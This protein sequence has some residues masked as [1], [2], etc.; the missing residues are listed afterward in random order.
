MYLLVKN[1]AI[2]LL[3]ILIVLICSITLNIV[4]YAQS[5]SYA[6]TGVNIGLDNSCNTLV[7][8]SQ[9]ATFLDPSCTYTL[10]FQRPGEPNA[11]PILTGADVGTIVNYTLMASDGTSCMGTIST[12]LSGAG[13]SIFCPSDPII[14]PCN[15]DIESFPAPLAFVCNG[16]V[17]L[18]SQNVTEIQQ[19]DCDATH[20]RVV[21]VNYVYSDGLNQTSCTVRYHLQAQDPAL[22]IAPT[23]I[24]FDCGPGLDIS[25]IATGLP[26][27]DGVDFDPA[28]AC[29]LM[30]SNPVD[31]RVPG[32][33]NTEVIT[34]TWNIMDMCSGGMTSISQQIVIQDIVHPAIVL[35]Q[36]VLQVNAL[37]AVCIS[38]VIDLPVALVSDQCSDPDQLNV[39]I[40]V[41]GQGVL[42]Q[43]GGFINGLA[44]G[45]HT[46]IYQVTDDCLLSTTTVLTIQ[47]TDATPPNV[48]CR[49]NQI[50][51]L[52]NLGTATVPAAAFDNGS[53]DNCNPV[54]YK[55]KRM[56]ASGCDQNPEFN[57][58]VTF[59]CE[60]VSAPVIV[61]LRV[62]DVNPGAG[63]VGDDAFTGRFNEC[64]VS[65]EVQDKLIP[66]V[67]C[68][69]ALTVNC[70]FDL[71]YYLTN[72]IPLATDNCNTNINI[73]VLLDRSGLNECGV[74]QAVRTMTYTDGENELVCIQN[75]TVENSVANGGISIVWPTNTMISGCGGDV[76]PD[77]LPVGSQRPIV[78]VSGCANIAMRSDDM[79]FDIVE[80]AC[81]KV[82]RTWEV[83]DWCTFDLET[84]T[85]IYRYHQLIKVLDEEAPILSGLDSIFIE[86]GVEEDCGAQQASIMM[87][88]I[89]ATDCT[90]ENLLRFRFRIDYGNN[91]SFDTGF[92]D[93]PDASGQFPSGIS[94]IQYRVEDR[95]GNFTTGERFVDVSIRD[96]KK[97][98]PVLKNL[99]TALMPGM[100]MVTI[101]AR[102][103]NAESSD[104]CSY[105]QNLR[106]SFSEQID[107]TQRIF[108]C[109]HI[110]TQFVTIYVWDE[111]G[112]VDF[113]NVWIVV[114]D[115]NG[116][117]PENAGGRTW[118]SGKIIDERQEEI[119]AVKIELLRSDK[120]PVMTNLEGSFMF[121]N[122]KKHRSYDICPTK[123][124]NPRNGVTV[125][126]LIKIQRHI[127]GIERLDSPYKMIAADAN[128]SGGISGADLVA[129]QRVILGFSD[130]FD[131]R[132]SWR[133]MDSDY[134]FADPLNPFSDPLPEMYTISQLDQAVE[135]RFIG[136]KIGDVDHSARLK[137]SL[138]ESSSRN[139]SKVEL[140]VSD[141]WVNQ[142]EIAELLVYAKHDLQV[143][144]IQG[145]INIVPDKAQLV[146]ISSR[147]L[148]GFNK[149]LVNDWKIMDGEL[150]FLWFD[151]KGIK[152]AEN[153]PLFRIK[154]HAKESGYVSDL[155]GGSNESLESII[156]VDGKPMSWM[157]RF[158]KEPAHDLVKLLQNKP[159][160]FDNETVLSFYLK[161]PTQVSI[162]VMD[163]AG[164][165]VYQR[166]G[167]FDAG[168]TDISIHKNIL[169]GSGV[170]MYRLDA[171]GFSETKRMVLVSN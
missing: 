137:S 96:L 4:S 44:A 138:I 86:I 40:T 89:S 111:A 47:V 113:A 66:T 72:E 15:T 9:I 101:E 116:E 26:R 8:P 59:C 29:N 90:P 147:N 24:T 41:P 76:S 133:F 68:P 3:N 154:M 108:T 103:F 20:Y 142:G 84:G 19:A 92:L 117:C 122:V 104:N 129:I 62:Y 27:Y 63:A 88:P 36:S 165:V 126:D 14:L 106:Y 30:I 87:S 139:T 149:D 21:D 155:F 134:E 7:T 58:Q 159:N 51:T 1:K 23:D 71:D 125:I 158:E 50:A 11:L 161:Y 132:P 100:Q 42:A 69:N 48:I 16:A 39:T 65:V 91:G 12:T 143:Q 57:D 35:P 167:Q 115:N 171:P 25:T 83:I 10:T 45:S 31:S 81:F 141:V 95:C 109:D 164:R 55:V 6:C 18:I 170:Y 37:P 144:G 146:S 112:N 105:P 32:C 97:P 152:L 5:C 53:S 120:V 124:V 145:A 13:P 2:S 130:K 93:G 70:E 38:G 123:D 67:V 98:T 110:D 28:S 153:A 78:T 135:K 46:I 163:M 79:V 52:N 136:V 114:A 85:G 60:D 33:G 99:T 102:M 157:I 73:E 107:D 140:Y 160:P 118:V 119:E 56:S 169:G 94:R 151:G 131:G 64:M 43:N 49:T 22:L 128:R 17:N 74:G 148:P 121:E 82:I 80:D 156:M 166:S 77:S 54:Y 34:R 162:S 127:L 168:T 150:S 61:I 75:I